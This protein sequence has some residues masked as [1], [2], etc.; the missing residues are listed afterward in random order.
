MSL[1]DE[2]KKLT[3]AVEENTAVLRQTLAASGATATQAPAPEPAKKKAKSKKADPAP[4]PEPEI[5]DETT[6]TKVGQAKHESGDDRP[7]E[8]E[9]EDPL[10][11][12]AKPSTPS[13]DP[14]AV[15]GEITETWK[16]MLVSADAD[17]KAKLKEA[18]P[19]LRSKWGLE[20]DDKLIALK[21]KPEN[22]VGLLNDI[23]AIEV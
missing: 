12:P 21:D 23:K 7:E 22:L 20:P 14:E 6:P 11:T 2:L 1:E 13:V 15:I 16:G 18:F 8:A 3:A 17:G 4:E 10:D 9:F 19:K 5:S